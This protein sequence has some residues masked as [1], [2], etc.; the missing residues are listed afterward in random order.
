MKRIYYLYSIVVGLSALLTITSSCKKFV[1]I[2]PPET[3]AE[4]SKIFAD[5]QTANSATVGLYSQMLGG[6]LSF[7]N[8]GITLY[9]ALSS[10]ELTNLSSNSNYDPFKTNSLLSSTSIIN[11]TFW[12]G[13]YKNIYQIN[14]ILEGLQNSKTLS[15][16]LKDQLQGEMLYSRAL[17]YFYLVNLYGEV[18]LVTGTDYQ[19]NAVMP[20]TTV[21]KIY[22]QII[23]DLKQ[24]HTLLSN[25]YA[26]STNQRPNRDA[27]AALLARVDL[28]KGNWAESESM[29]TEVINSGRYTLESLTNAFVSTSKETI[30]QISKQTGNVS[31]ASSFIPSST[32]AKP[33]FS[34][35]SNLMAAFESGDNRKTT[36]LKSNTV[37]G[38]AYYYP[39]KY[40]V[41]T[42]TPITEYLVIMRLAEQYLIRAEARANLNNLSSAIDDID[43]IRSRA[44]LLTIKSQN[45]AIGKSDLLIA[46]LKERQTELFTEWGNRWFDLKRTGNADAILAP[47]K[48]PNWQSTDKLY[49]IPSPQILVNP[50]LTQNNGYTN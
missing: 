2:S 1:E 3:Q 18:P 37:S 48:A 17:H 33:T 32:T 38:V 13:P 28:Y 42:S 27:A 8:G 11:S 21:D 40:K 31:E 6:S 29:A 5:D 22:D 12:I 43:K 20:R 15:A 44:G 49:P 9:A 39:Y 47:I 45:P 7:C 30:Y 23:A 25:S 16:N 19:V 46:I 4:L 14:A 50:F 34:I 26:S 24:A 41:R 35:G 36:W 10:D